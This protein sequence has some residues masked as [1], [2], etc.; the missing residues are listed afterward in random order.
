MH[1]VVC[2][3][4]LLVASLGAHAQG[5]YVGGGVGSS[6]VESGNFDASDVG[7]QVF[8]GY[9]FGEGAL[10]L[11]S[12]LSVEGSYVDFGTLKD[13]AFGQ[14]FRLD[15]DGIKLYAVVTKPL[16]ARWSIL[17]KLGLLSWDGRAMLGSD[18]SPNDGSDAAAAI[19][20]EFQTSKRSLRIRGEIEGFDLLD[21]VWLWSVSA[22]HQFKRN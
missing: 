21:G 2:C 17:G 4:L 15:L 16:G 7:I 18:S 11:E 9:R 1:R 3:G 14:Q 22:V 8:G 6:Q 13:D 12:T 20:F 10:P 5:P 19:G